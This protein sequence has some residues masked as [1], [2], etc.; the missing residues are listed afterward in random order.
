MAQPPQLTDVQMQLGQVNWLGIGTAI[1]DFFVTGVFPVLIAILNFFLGLGPEALK[2]MFLV[3][4]VTIF[5]YKAVR[6]FIGSK[7]LAVVLSIVIAVLGIR[8]IPLNVIELIFTPWI[9]TFFVLI[10]WFFVLFIKIHWRLRRFVL[11]ASIILFFVLAF[12]TK[13]MNYVVIGIIF[14][15][16]L[17]LDSPLNKAFFKAEQRTKKVAELK[18]KIQ[19]R[20]DQIESL[21]K[22]KAEGAEINE[23]DIKSLEEEKKKL[24][25]ELAKYF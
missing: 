11:I 19:Q 20:S 5:I 14:I 12:F 7:F 8:I 24:V 13:L 18:A 22:A 17:V 2:R 25:A 3:F 6:N 21:K 9:L 15:V 1:Q 16:L 10:A 23:S 4:I